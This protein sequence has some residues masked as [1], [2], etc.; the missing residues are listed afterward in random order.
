MKTIWDEIELIDA[1]T[2]CMCIDCKCGA[3]EKNSALKERHKLVLFLMGLNE[4]YTRIKGNIM[5]MQPSPTIDIA[6][7]LLLHEERQRNI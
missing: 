3:L 5:M 1:R 2:V 6:Y 4:T 7:Y